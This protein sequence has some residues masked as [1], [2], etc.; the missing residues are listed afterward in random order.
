[1]RAIINLSLPSQTVKIVKKAVKE[2]HYATTSEFFRCLLRDWQERK[3][4]NELFES[5][6]EI[7][8]GRGKILRS[9]KDLR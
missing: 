4:L 8:S 5:R 6:Q 7:A 2:G 1:M 3:L 9:L